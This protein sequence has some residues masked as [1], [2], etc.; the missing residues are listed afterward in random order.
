MREQYQIELRR[1]AEAY[2]ELDEDRRGYLTG[3]NQ[4]ASDEIARRFGENARQHLWGVEYRSFDD[5]RRSIAAAG[6]STA[7][8]H[9]DR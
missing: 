1:V 5:F 6:Q 4:A 8:R 9:G 2:Y 7:T 3:Y